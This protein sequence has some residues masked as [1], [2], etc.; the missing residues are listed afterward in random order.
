MHSEFAVMSGTTS[1]QIFSLSLCRVIF[2]YRKGTESFRVL[3]CADLQSTN[4][5]EL[6]R[7][8]GFIRE[9]MV[10]QDLAEIRKED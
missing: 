2:N 7:I 4:R 1:L 5:A 3:D 6:I 9:L 10:L 8:M